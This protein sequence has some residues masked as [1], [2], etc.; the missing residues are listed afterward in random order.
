MASVC[1][2]RNLLA[3]SGIAA[4]AFLWSATSFAQASRPS[5]TENPAAELNKYPGLLQE[6]GQLLQKMQDGVQ[7]PQARSQSRLLPLL[8]ASTVYYIAIPNYGDSAQQALTVFH[9]EL[10]TNAVLNKWW[11]SRDMAE[12]GQKIEDAIGKFSQLS[13]FLGDEI[14]VSGS[15]DSPDH[16]IV[17]IAEVR[18]P[19]L[20]EFIEQNLAELPGTTAVKVF[21]AQT[22]ASASEISKAQHLTVLV[23]PDFVVSAGS[24]KA[25]RNF[26]RSLDQKDGQF[27]TT[28]FGQRMSASY[29]NGTSVLAGVNIEALLKQMP[30][31]MAAQRQTLQSTGFADA[32]Y[33]VW[34][35]KSIDGQATSQAELS[36]NGPRRGIASW[37]AAPVPPRSLDFVSPHAL[38]AGTVVLKNLA[39]VFADI[40][41]LTAA[42]NPKQMASLEQMQQ[43]LNLDLQKD[44]LHH[45]DGELTL[46]IEGA[47]PDPAWML[48]ARIN[49]ANGLQQTLNKLLMTMPVAPEDFEENGVHYHV[50]RI[51]AGPKPMEIA[52]AFVDKY[53]LV[54]SSRG[55]ATAAI[56][57]RQ[58]G[59]SLS[60]FPKLQAA[61][62]PGHPEG[63]SALLYE[64]PIAAAALSVGRTS[65][66]MAGL[67]SQMKGKS[68]P[69]VIC[70]Y[71]TPNAIREASMNSGAD[72]GVILIA[73]AVA[74]PNLLRARI[75]ANES[76]AVAILRTINTAEVSYTVSYPQKGYARDL[77]T[78]AP[79]PRG[80]GFTSSRHAGLIDQS[81]SSSIKDGYGFSLRPVCDVAKC[82]DYVAVALPLSNSTGSR[83]FC[84][85]SDAVIRVKMGMATTSPLSVA[86]CRRWAPLD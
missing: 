26:S 1:R 6:L 54:A 49:D 21:D 25:L 52:Y 29:H 48:A 11:H 72:A 60:N 86:E 45:F 10:A 9:Q 55:I 39:D 66:E 56:A 73:A 20:K 4:S 63:V 14:V 33:L 13:Q 32:K 77:A 79:D 36:F 62:P 74:I 40:E 65:P 35:H 5:G 31:A 37:L 51:P 27:G 8:P 71:G 43:A 3:V 76:S 23:R 41:K 61:I 34:E 50:L 83:S 64:D 15:P 47:Q 53:L 30:P 7:S 42:Q 70:A 18:K 38:F 28:P 46:A 82:S 59:D 85:T 57:R 68:S 80:P 12:Q 67:F 69:V 44:L 22:L 78:L 81:L 75:A 24:V 2:W 84:S 17:L 19:G 58:S 16:A